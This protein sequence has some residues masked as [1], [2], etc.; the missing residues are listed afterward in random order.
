MGIVSS[1]SWCPVHKWKT[2]ADTPSQNSLKLSWPMKETASL[3]SGRTEGA[4]CLLSWCSEKSLSSGFS[5]P[6][7]ALT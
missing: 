6:F 3:L 4:C 2:E 1:V 7:F 5:C